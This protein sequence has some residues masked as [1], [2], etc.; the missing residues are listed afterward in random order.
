MYTSVCTSNPLAAASS[1][2]ATLYRSLMLYK[3][4]PGTTVWYCRGILATDGRV[5]LPGVGDGLVGRFR[6]GR[7]VLVAR[8][9]TV[10]ATRLVGAGAFVAGAQLVAE[11]C[12]VVTVFAVGIASDGIGVDGTR[13]SITAVGDGRCSIVD[14]SPMLSGRSRPIRDPCTV[15]VCT[16]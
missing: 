9:R 16:P 1:L 8:G 3:L 13:T 15:P 6:S 2:T 12:G 11:G 4:S 7:T 10:R 14:P 5:A